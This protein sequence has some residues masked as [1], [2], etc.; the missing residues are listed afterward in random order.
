VKFPS[1]YEEGQA[2]G[3]YDVKLPGIPTFIQFKLSDELTTSKAL[4]SAA[5]GLPYFR[6]KIRG[7]KHSSQH[8]LLLDLEA[9]GKSVYYAAPRFRLPDSMNRAFIDQEMIDRTAF[10]RPSTIGAFDP[11]DDG[12]HTLSFRATGSQAIL[13]SVKK[14]LTLADFRTELAEADLS[15]LPLDDF[16][17]PTGFD[18]RELGDLLVETYLSRTTGSDRDRG[19]RLRDTLR[20]IRPHSYVGFAASNLFGAEMIVVNP[21][22]IEQP[23]P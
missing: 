3:G 17:E 11:S 5:L 14:E 10:I 23:T 2:G 13:H 4:D 12:D 9:K 18:V 7:R 8:D 21:S 15:T 16:G 19:T 22:N 1:L 20:D 6:F